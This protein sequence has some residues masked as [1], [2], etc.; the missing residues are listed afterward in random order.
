MHV[1]RPRP[2]RRREASAD[3]GSRPRP[4]LRVRN[5][6]PHRGVG[7]QLGQVRWVDPADPRRLVARPYLTADRARAET[8]T[9]P[10][11]DLEELRELLNAGTAVPGSLAGASATAATGIRHPASGI[12]TRYPAASA[13]PSR[14]LQQAPDLCGSGGSGSSAPHR[15]GP[16]SPNPRQVRTLLTGVREQR[17][18][19]RH[20]EAF[21]GCLYHATMRP[22]RGRRTAREPVPPS[23]DGVGDA[24]PAA[25]GVRAGRSWT[26]D[27]STQHFGSGT[28][29]S[30]HALPRETPGG[31]ALIDG[32]I[33]ALRGET[34]PRPVHNESNRK[35]ANERPPL[36]RQVT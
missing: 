6:E 32:G 18:R 7:V 25:R 21:F 19:G 10:L 35:Q 3:V 28:G 16:P 34:H 15:R 23:R 13:T 29:R 27:G 12:R 11:T 8:D 24:R 31:H 26:D 17:P 5:P 9:E 22:V 36:T 1:A 20:L 2:G 30:D 14:Y 4:V 33:W